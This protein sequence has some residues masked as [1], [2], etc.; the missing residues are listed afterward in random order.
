MSASLK[1]RVRTFSGVAGLAGIALVSACLKSTEPQP[2]LL[3]LSGHWVYTGE[4]T[5]PVREIFTGTLDITRESG[6]S[7]NG[8]MSFIA[9]NTQT[10]V[11]RVLSGF[12]SGT[13]SGS[14][15]IDFDAALQ[16]GP[17]RHIGQ[18]VADTITGNWVGSTAESPIP[19]GTFR[20]ERESR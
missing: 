11:E 14:D 10:Q 8:Q 5:S 13:E 15:V 20:I 12:I 4:Q 7:F 1:T 3:Q 19:S 9:R 2:S 6:T 18:I 17:R 16:S